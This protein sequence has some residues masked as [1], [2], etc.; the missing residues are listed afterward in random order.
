MPE[1]A[2][3]TSA[4]FNQKLKVKYQ[5]Y[6]IRKHTSVSLPVPNFTKIRD[7]VFRNI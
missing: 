3:R 1:T 2:L 5:I 4:H 7:R 6:F